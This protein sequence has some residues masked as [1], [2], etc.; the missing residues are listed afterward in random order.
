MDRDT[1]IGPTSYEP[2]PVLNLFHTLSL[3]ISLTNSFTHSLTHTLTHSLTHT[4]THSHT[5][6]LFHSLT[7]SR[8]HIKIMSLLV[9]PNKSSKSRVNVEVKFRSFTQY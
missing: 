9:C 7:H 2:I 5:H 1:W 3:S 4:L 8:T 6:S